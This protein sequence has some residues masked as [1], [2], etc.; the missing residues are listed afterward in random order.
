MNFGLAITTSFE[1]S[2]EKSSLI[3]SLSDDL[4][5]HFKNKNYGSSIQSFTIGI[6]CCS[7][8]FDQFYTDLKPKYTKG[9]RVIKR[10]TW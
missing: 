6:V 3:Q 4:K 2:L 1:I 7:P 10:R 8:K 9:K 5:E